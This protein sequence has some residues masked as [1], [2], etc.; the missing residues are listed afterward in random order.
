MRN[1]IFR[2]TT[3]SILALLK[4]VSF[5]IFFLC[6][7]ITAVRLLFAKFTTNLKRVQLPF[8]TSFDSWPHLTVVRFHSFFGSGGLVGF[9]PGWCQQPPLVKIPNIVFLFQVLRAK[10]AIATLMTVPIMSAKMEGRVLMEST[11]TTVS[12]AQNSQ[13]CNVLSCMPKTPPPQ[14]K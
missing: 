5:R 4:H 14:N 11:L 10:T 8:L 2:S 6:N 7:Y 12:V 13:V 3:F 9:M 1:Y